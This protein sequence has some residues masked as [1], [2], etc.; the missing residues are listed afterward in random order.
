MKARKNIAKNSL[1]LGEGR[2]GA[3]LTLKEKFLYWGGTALL[4]IG[5]LFLGAKKVRG[6]VS[7]REE[8]KAFNEGDP[9]NYAKRIKMAFENDGW[10]GT[11]IVKLRAAFMEIPSKEMFEKVAKSYSRDYHSSLYRDLS[12]ELQSTEY[13]EMLA[14]KEAKPDRIRKK[15]ENQLT[16]ANYSF[17]AK[18]I[19]SAFD[20][21][22]GFLP[23]TDE[24]ALKA[25][26][27]EI[28]TQADFV[29]VGK[30]Y[31]RL[32][33]SNMLEDLKDEVG[34]LDYSDWM[35]IITAKPQ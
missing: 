20:K 23:G 29:Q 8:K 25:V 28:P 30:E 16:A 17:W 18:R 21:E 4:T 24:E 11:D 33:K 31:A 10:P 19:K 5:F 9:A 7:N 2:G 12:D 15:N 3:A 6:A 1:P 13:S 14:I 26:F 27:D 32:Y 34:F 22:Y 35:K